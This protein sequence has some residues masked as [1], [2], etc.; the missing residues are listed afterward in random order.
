[1]EDVNLELTLTAA[2]TVITVIG[3]VITIWQ[4]LKVKAIRKQIAFDLRKI[5]LS[6]VGEFLRRAQDEGRK[7]LTHVQQL[8]RGKSTISITSE[9]QSN[10][11]KSLNLLHLTGPDSDLRGQIIS[12]QEKL[13]EFQKTDDSEAQK[14]YASDMHTLIQDSISMCK[15]RVSNLEY[16]DKND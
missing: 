7:L 9:I 4:A 1:M 15:E 16:G 5:H 11:D 2:G 8:S 14:Q 10:I 6:E 12:S 13:R 3:T